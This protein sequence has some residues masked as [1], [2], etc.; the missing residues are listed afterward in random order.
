MERVMSNNIAIFDMDGCVS[1][2]QW[3]RG[4][5]RQHQHGEGKPEDYTE[6]H[7]ACD[8][9]P[10]MKAGASVLHA[11]IRQGD[12]IVFATARPFAVAKKS[13]EWVVKHFGI[14]P[15]QDFL[16]MMRKDGD[17][18]SAVEVKREMAAWIR[19]YAQKTGKAVTAAFDDRL[20]IAKLWKSEGYKSYV[21]DESG[22]VALDP[23]P[24]S[25]DEIRTAGLASLAAQ[26]DKQP[27]APSQ[28]AAFSL[29]PA[30]SLTPDEREFVERLNPES[31][32][33]QFLASVQRNAAD[34]LAKAAD[35]F[36]E[37]NANYKDNAVNVGKVMQALFP[38]G[39]TIR[40]NDDHHLYHLFELIIVKLTRF[41][42]SGLTHADS[43]HDAAVYAAMVE[44]IVHN[45]N[46]EVH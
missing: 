40:S 13:A 3:R 44:A 45:H 17:G 28:P 19:D 25:V 14:Q 23:Q 20:D 4:R 24:T 27:A 6:Y 18:R 42:N 1:D 21:L 12:F 9:D 10:P 22:I 38:N 15:T 33:G 46:I 7:E 16:I 34:I 32:E 35:T 37:R 29:E 2:D 36:R 26:S 41:A 5:V 30:A 39:V 11:H 43:I 8:Q 31:V